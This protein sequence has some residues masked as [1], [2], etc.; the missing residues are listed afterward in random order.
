VLPPI[1][2]ALAGK[3]QQLYASVCQGCHLAPVG[4]PTFWS[5]DRW[6]QLNAT[7]P[8]ILDL[9]LIPTAHVGTD[10]A[11]ATGLA[12]RQ[13]NTPPTMGI[14]ETSF[15][16]ALGDLVEKVVDKWYGDQTPPVPPNVQQQMNGD[17]PNGIQAKLAYKV[18]PLD[19]IWATP[20]YLHNGSVPTLYDLLS[21][22]AERPKVFYSGNREFDPV[23]VGLRTDAAP[24]L[25]RF[26]TS[27]PG[28][29]NTGH[30]FSDTP[31]PGV[32]GRFLQPDERTA[33]VEY[34]KTL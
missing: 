32:I 9:E 25:S 3:G 29:L 1:D 12:G 20:P 23:K 27:I 16:P 22:A 7:G 33:I 24:G 4:T 15:G 8:R 31:G 6:I 26:D 18:R 34:L 10:P 19:G 21:P 11:Q 30:E 13:V 5:S 17:R 14:S 2:A 28:N